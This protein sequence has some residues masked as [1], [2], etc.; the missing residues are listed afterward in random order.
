MKDR[1]V[2]T[3]ENFYD[4]VMKMLGGPMTSAKKEVAYEARPPLFRDRFSP[5]KDVARKDPATNRPRDRFGFLKVDFPP[6][7]RSNV[8]PFPTSRIVRVRRRRVK[9][10]EV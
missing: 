7:P 9:L 10:E 2:I 5:R 6:P 8:I 4:E 3:D 1:N